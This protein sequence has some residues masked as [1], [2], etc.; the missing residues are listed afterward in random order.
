MARVDP[1]AVSRVIN[2]DPNLNIAP[3]TRARILDAVEKLGYRPNVV[4]RGFR[5]SRTW[6]IGFVVPDIGNPVY[7]PIIE[8]A[9]RRAEEL[10]YGIVIGSQRGGATDRTFLRL[11]RE[12]RVDGLLIASG[13]MHD[14]L[15]RSLADDG[16]GP[17]VL[18]NRQ[19]EGFPC[20]VIVDDEAGSQLATTHL[21][22]Q[23]HREIGALIGP[24]NIDTSRRRKDGFRAAIRERGGNGHVVSSK[25]WTT[26]DGYNATPRLLGRYPGITAIFS[27]TLLMAFGALRALEERGIKVPEEMSVVALHDSDLATYTSP[28]LTTVAMP[29]QELGSAAVDLLLEQMREGKTQSVLVPGPGQLITRQSVA[30]PR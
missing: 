1:S 23:G 13:T 28:P 2:N 21:L 15:M 25:S 4:A 22:D 12:G 8:G 24:P 6:T 19:V 9:Q 17:V 3:Q 10:G 26:A 16:G 30:A 20:S 5:V 29:T 27:S 11:L 18:V 7:V 14:D